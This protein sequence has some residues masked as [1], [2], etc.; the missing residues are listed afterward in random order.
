MA[1]N[2]ATPPARAADARSRAEAPERLRPRYALPIMA[3]PAASAAPTITNPSGSSGRRL[4]TNSAHK[5]HTTTSDAQRT[6]PGPMGARESSTA[7]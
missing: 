3:R 2:S 1:G 6:R 7:A 5:H 4:A